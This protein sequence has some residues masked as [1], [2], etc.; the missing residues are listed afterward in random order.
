MSSEQERPLLLTAHYSLLTVFLWLLP[1]LIFIGPARRFLTL[2]TPW[3]ALAAGYAIAQLIHPYILKYVRILPMAI[4]AMALALIVAGEALYAYNSVIV[5]T[6]K[7]AEPWAY[8]RLRREAHSWGF[9][10]LEAHLSS[11]LK[12]KMPA[13]GITFQFPFSQKLLNEAVAQGR[14]E[15]R[16]A[17]PWG[18][19]YNDNIS[20]SAQLWIFLRRISYEGWPVMSA[21]HFRRGGG[22]EFLRESGIERVIFVNATE[23]ALQDR[24]RPN[25]PDGD[26]V[27]AELRAEGIAPREIKNA[28]GEI[29]FLAYEFSVDRN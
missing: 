4:P 12:G 3:L 23:F 25:S 15:K 24:A 27:E 9:N 7:G 14:Q 13:V 11:V 8:S 28:R 5:L 21:E 16:E 22:E 20:L 10:E 1:F 17:V 2:L 26:L 29:A 18:I 6:P 19:V